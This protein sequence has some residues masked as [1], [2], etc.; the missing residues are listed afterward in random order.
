MSLRLK[1][2]K[3]NILVGE[4]LPGPESHGNN[5]RYIEQKLKEKGFSVSNGSGVDLVDLNTEVKSR[6]IGST[7]YHTVGV[8]SIDNI[9]KCSYEETHLYEKTLNQYRVKY[10]DKTHTIVS[11]SI[12]DFSDPTIQKEI[13]NAYEYGRKEIA[14]GKRSS[15]ISCAPVGCFERA[16]DTS[17]QFRL[18]N[19]FMKKI[20]YIAKSTFKNHFDFGD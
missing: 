3:N 16:S 12:Y 7:S 5:G 19:G 10:D 15:Y 6:K 1:S 18:S 4:S 17:Y 9:I 11:E 2:I 13:K 14:E 20:E 8:I